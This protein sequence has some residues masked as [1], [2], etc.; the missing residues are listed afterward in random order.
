MEFV[1]KCGATV[2]NSG[3]LSKTEGI[4]HVN[5][6]TMGV[7]EEWYEHL[8][9][10]EL[11]RVKEKDMKYTPKYDYPRRLKLV[12]NSKSNGGN[13]IKAVNTWAVA[14]LLYG[15]GVIRWTK[16]ELQYINRMT[17]KMMTMNE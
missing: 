16:N 7:N 9:M 2:V 8:G 10:M 6:E 4:R 17:R 5:G 13:K 15:G 12:K 1:L 3:K 11:D 14:L